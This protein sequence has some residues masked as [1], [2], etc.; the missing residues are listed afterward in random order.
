MCAGVP[1]LQADVD[2]AKEL[3]GS[4]RLQA[5]LSEYFLLQ[6]HNFQQLVDSFFKSFVFEEG[7]C[8]FS[9]SLDDPLVLSRVDLLIEG[10]DLL[11]AGQGTIRV[12]QLIEV[13]AKLLVH[14]CDFFG[15]GVVGLNQQ[16]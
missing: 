11:D 7:S 14:F 1:H 5:G 3:E 9:S 8:N 10:L 6:F 4:G 15:L 16:V 2:S 12:S 13:L